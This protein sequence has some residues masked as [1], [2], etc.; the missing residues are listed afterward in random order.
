MTLRIRELRLQKGLS[1]RAMAKRAGIAQSTLQELENHIKLPKL[2]EL[3]FI[4]AS[5]QVAVDDLFKQ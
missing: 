1:Q 3:E 4:A 2:K 5:L